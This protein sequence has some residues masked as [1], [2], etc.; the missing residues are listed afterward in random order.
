[1]SNKYNFYEL[2][3]YNTADVS[4]SHVDRW[5]GNLQPCDELCLRLPEDIGYFPKSS[6]NADKKQMSVAKIKNGRIFG[7]FMYATKNN[8]FLNSLSCSRN[9]HYLNFDSISSG[10]ITLPLPE[11]INGTALSLSGAWGSYYHFLY[12]HLPCLALF[13]GI[14]LD[15][16]LCQNQLFAKQALTSLGLSEK[17]ILIVN[18]NKSYEFS[19]LFKCQEVANYYYIRKIANYFSSL[20]RDKTHNVTFPKKIL[21]SRNIAGNFRRIVNEKEVFSYLNPKGF[22]LVFLEKLSF[23]EQVQLFANAEFIVGACGAGLGN[24]IFCSSSCKV[25]ELLGSYQARNH[26]DDLIWGISSRNRPIKWGQLVV[27]ATA[28][29]LSEVFRDKE[30]NH[31]LVVNMKKFDHFYKFIENL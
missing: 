10:N 30:N 5:S 26:S 8:D 29:Y 27:E 22:T 24:A 21:I 14:K 19:Y 18:S 7:C 25:I 9:D 1:M 6:K 11:K 31:D 13:E 23:I 3:E 15:Y 16:I 28:E 17:Q 12:D 20:Y 4:I 2:D